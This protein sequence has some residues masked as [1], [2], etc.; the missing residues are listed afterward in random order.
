MINIVAKICRKWTKLRLQPIRVFC[1]HHVSDTMDET[2]M[3]ACDWMQ[4]DIFKQRIERLRAMGYSFISLSKAHVK[5]QR[6]IFRCH[7]YAVLTADDGWASIMNILPWLQEQQIPITLFLNPAYLDGMHFRVR[8]TEKY[9]SKEEVTQLHERYPLVTV[10][11]HGWEHKN[12]S[13]QSEKEFKQSL[14]KSEQYLGKLPNYIPYMAYTW[15]QYT[16]VTDECLRMHN[17]IPVYIDGEKN[18]NDAKV[19][20]RELL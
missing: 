12:A 18:Y 14:K 5:M 15:G 2:T 16:T 8:E 3:E 4:T 1:F 7:K 6:D 17:I 11:M 20:H 9:L 19:V 10:G 13:K